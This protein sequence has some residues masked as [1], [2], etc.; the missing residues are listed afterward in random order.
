VGGCARRGVARPP[1]FAASAC[2]R[3]RSVDDHTSH[4]TATCP[5]NSSA[6]GQT[7]RST[8]LHAQQ[9]Q[10]VSGAFDSHYQPVVVIADSKDSM[11]ASPRRAARG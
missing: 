11:L 7:E 1:F 4:A 3:P 5:F 2:A 10:P 6:R 9:I 8:D